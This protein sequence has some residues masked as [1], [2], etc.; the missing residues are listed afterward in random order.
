[1][2]KDSIQV[3]K[4]DIVEVGTLLAQ[5]GNSGTTSEPHLHI[6]HQGNYPSDSVFLITDEGLPMI[7]E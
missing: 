6:Q 2:K 4:G 1:L 5:V 7:F 3:N